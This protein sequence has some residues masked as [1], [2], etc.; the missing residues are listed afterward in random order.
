[1]LLSAKPADFGLTPTPEL[2]RVWAAMM[3]WQVSNALVSLVAVAEGSTSLYFGTGGGI[4]GGGEHES[5]RRENRKL[6]MFIEKSLEMFVSI[7]SPLEALKGSVA[8]AVLTYGGFRGA[9]DRE[10]R[11]TQQKSPLWPVYYLGQGVITA[12]RLATERP[13]GSEPKV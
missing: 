8:F 2:P 11:I 3:E 5:V 7:D 10:E 9:R 1:M 6:L 4:L 12:L 13:S